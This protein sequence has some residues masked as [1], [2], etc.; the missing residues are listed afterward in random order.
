LKQAESRIAQA[1]EA[2]Q[3]SEAEFS[4]NADIN[5]TLV[6]HSDQLSRKLA[7]EITASLTQKGFKVSQSPWG[8]PMPPIGRDIQIE[9]QPVAKAKADIV[10]N[11]VRT[12]FEKRN[13][14]N[15]ITVME[16]KRPISNNPDAHVVVFFR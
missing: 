9:Y 15:K 2:A 12:I 8:E 5:V 3:T 7:R 4:S 14:Q 13:L 16:K 6:P 11:I 10:A 1:R